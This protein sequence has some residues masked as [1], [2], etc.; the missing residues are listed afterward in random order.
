MPLSGESGMKMPSKIIVLNHKDGKTF[1]PLLYSL[2]QI[3]L[4]C[5]LSIPLPINIL[6]YTKHI[7]KK[8]GDEEK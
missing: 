6:L 5:L 2:K 8:K 7:P 1:L 4:F 3:I